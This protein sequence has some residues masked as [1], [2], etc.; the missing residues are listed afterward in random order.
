M[1]RPRT[2]RRHGTRI[3]RFK[4]KWDP[5][6]TGLRFKH[7]R[8]ERAG[9]WGLALN[10]E[11][12][13]IQAID[14]QLVQREIPSDKWLFF[15]GM[16][17]RAAHK[18]LLYGAQTLVYGIEELVEEFKLRG[19]DPDQVSELVGLG[20]IAVYITGGWSR[21]DFAKIDVTRIET[22][23]PFDFYSDACS[24]DYA[25]CCLEVE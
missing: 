6:V 1:T 3:A 13:L 9:Y 17:A 12:G 10:V 8:R 19:L 16:V 25:F 11:E 22:L 7:Y 2:R 5:Q 24:A 15:E 18:A 14:E 21:K 20:A 4:N 23:T